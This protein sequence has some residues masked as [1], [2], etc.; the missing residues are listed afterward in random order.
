MAWR[1]P[2][3]SP[4]V[5]AEMFMPHWME[6]KKLL[7]FKLHG[8]PDLPDWYG[9]DSRGNKNVAL[10][11]AL[12]QSADLDGAVVIAIVCYGADSEMQ[13]AFFEA[14]AV[15]FFGSPVVVR[16]REQRPGEADILAA[17]LLRLLARGPQDL[18]GALARAKELYMVKR[19]EWTEHDEFTL[20]TWTLNEPAKGGAYA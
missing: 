20:A 8:Y 9:M 1:V 4:P 3:T 19:P 2:I 18:S 14:G 15:A 6:G 7:V 17:Y 12:V 11:P 5:R 13:Q 16:A 10:T